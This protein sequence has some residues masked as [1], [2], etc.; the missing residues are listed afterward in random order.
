MQTNQNLFPSQEEAREIKSNSEDV[1][2]CRGKDSPLQ[3]ES[4]KL[5]EHRQLKCN[6]SCW[7]PVSMGYRAV[8][9]RRTCSPP[10]HL[11]WLYN[12]QWLLF[13]PSKPTASHTLHAIQRP[14]NNIE[15]TTPSGPEPGALMPLCARYPLL[16][17]SVVCIWTVLLFT[18]VRESRHPQQQLPKGSILIAPTTSR[19][20]Q[21]ILNWQNKGETQSRSVPPQTAILISAFNPQK[22]SELLFKDVF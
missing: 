15:V 20:N 9:E 1:V 6:E 4:P 19:P 22:A 10:C 16:C 17:G 14:R 5:L 7:A 21:F 11:S 12:A 18:Q 2:A 13:L 3:F 8:T